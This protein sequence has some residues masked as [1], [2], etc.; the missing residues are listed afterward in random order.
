MAG[1]DLLLLSHRYL[2]DLA[3]GPALRGYEGS[4]GREDRRSVAT[5]GPCR[6]ALCPGS[7]QS[8]EADTPERRT[9]GRRPPPATRVAFGDGM[10]RSERA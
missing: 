2:G 6:D 9:T 5:A 1:W 8:L 10:I 7:V 4:G 3:Q